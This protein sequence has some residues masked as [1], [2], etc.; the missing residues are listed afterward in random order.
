MARTGC[1]SAIGPIPIQAAR[2]SPLYV[3]WLLVRATSP[4]VGW[5]AIRRRTRVGHVCGRDRR[6]WTE[7]AAPAGAR[8]TPWSVTLSTV[9]APLPP[10]TQA[11]R[12]RRRDQPRSRTRVGGG[13]E[14]WGARAPSTPAT[15]SYVAHRRLVHRHR[16]RRP[17]GAGAT[18][19][20]HQRPVAV[21]RRRPRGERGAD[22]GLAAAGPCRETRPDQ[23]YRVRCDETTNPPEAIDDGPG[24]LRDRGGTGHRRWSSSRCA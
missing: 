13:L 1:G 9:A 19:L 24:G 20:R 14:I 23:A 12:S 10:Q 16:A 15:A 5:I 21:V 7:S 4:D 8:P 3:P 2:A 6:V 11:H 22:G 17:S 18:G